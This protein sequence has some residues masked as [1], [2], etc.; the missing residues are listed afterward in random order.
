M[1]LGKQ[2]S[3][4]NAYTVVPEIINASLK[5]CKHRVC[6]KITF[7]QYPYIAMVGSLHLPGTNMRRAYGSHLNLRLFFN[8][9]KSMA[10]KCIEATPLPHLYL[11]LIELPAAFLSLI[12]FFNGL[13]SVA[14][15]C[16]EA[17]PMLHLYLYLIEWLA[18]FIPLT[19]F[20]TD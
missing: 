9:L 13:K 19:L 1:H 11:Y 14:T 15:K 10:T 12:L 7:L 20:S 5:P 3:F 6:K 17:T 18:A 8:G 16:T 2:V 4:F